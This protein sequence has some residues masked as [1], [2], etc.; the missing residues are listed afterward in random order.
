MLD[1]KRMHHGSVEPI[2]TGR[3]PHVP[4]LLVLRDVLGMMGTKFG[5]GM[6]LR[7]ACTVHVDSVA[8]RS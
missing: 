1:F 5:R 6:A 8:T 2:S 7:G 4:L 3:S